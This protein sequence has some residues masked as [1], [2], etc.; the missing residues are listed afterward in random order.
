MRLV[1]SLVLSALLAA[2]LPAIVNP[3]LQP[4]HLM[5]RYSVVLGGEVLA[6]DA[7]ARSFTLRITEV[8]KGTF[9]VKEVVVDASS[10]AVAM[11]FANIRA[12][13]VITAFVGKT[14]R[15][16]ERELM[17][18]SGNGKWGQGEMAEGD[19]GHWSWTAD[20]DQTQEEGKGAATMWGTFA[21]REDRLLE[22]MRDQARGTAF[23]NPIP[24]INF[25]NDVVVG[26]L[27][28]PVRGVALHDLDGDGRPEVIATSE[29]GVTVWSQST[30]MVFSDT[31]EKMGLTG[32][33][34]RSVGIA[35]ATGSGRQDLLLDGAIW[36]RGADGRYVQS[37]LLPADA[38]EVLSAAFVEINGDGWPDVVVSRVG[39]GLS[40][41]LNPGPAGGAFAD[42]T[43]AAGLAK[44]ECGGGGSGW[45]AP[46]PVDWDGGTRAGLWYASGPGFLLHQ[47]TKGVFSPVSPELHLSAETGSLFD[48]ST[49][50][51]PG[52]S[53]GAVFAAM[54]TQAKPT[55]FLPLDN[56]FRTAFWEDGHM[57]NATPWANELSERTYYQSFSIAEDLDM[58]GYIDTWTASRDGS[59]ATQNTC[60]INRGYGS[61]MRAEKYKHADQTDVFNSE[62]HLKGAGGAA[63]GDADGDG[64]TDLLIGSLDGTVSLLRS[65]VLTG[66]KQANPNAPYHQRKL[67]ATGL[68]S[69]R[70]T[71]KQGVLG[72]TVTIA[73]A[74]GRILG[75]R[76][77]G[78]NVASGCRSPDTVDFAVREPGACMV[79]VRFSDG[80][81][82]SLPAEAK[83]LAQV[84]VLADRSAAKK[85]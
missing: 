83:S 27:A 59:G 8:V 58:D 49:S 50:R 78:S 5:D 21:G 74:D 32:V 39:G 41:Y 71:G 81:L 38:R 33:N 3:G 52:R 9:V 44:P 19:P 30:S 14:R 1:A 51:T 77:L 61:W 12:G 72:A 4:I 64:C 60:H 18:Y 56:D 76:D 35:D 2:P 46:A 11:S 75:R 84:L 17:L 62:A 63:A 47:D 69:V 13:Q 48:L 28:G 25:D 80:A 43:T 45:F 24:E 36:L 82:L 26:K 66:R 73:A 29:K 67:Q 6:V 40:V 23:F 70:V 54:W 57:V 65:D 10:E 20:P 79:T 16:R 42:R 53:G 15:G 22:L 85:P 34:A 55:L 68:V 7:K 37:K 31:T